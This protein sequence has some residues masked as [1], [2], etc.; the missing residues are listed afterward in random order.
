MSKYTAEQEAEAVER[1]RSYEVTMS[2]SWRND[3]SEDGQAADEQRR[4]DM[5][6][7]VMGILNCEEADAEK[8]Y[9]Q[10]RWP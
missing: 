9:D 8:F 6:S 5:I 2:D 10:K 1:I 4:E 7:D 3:F